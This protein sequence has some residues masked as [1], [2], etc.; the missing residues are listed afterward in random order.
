M[1]LQKDFGS[2]VREINGVTLL[3]N[4]QRFSDKGRPLHLLYCYW[5]PTRQH[6]KIALPVRLPPRTFCAPPGAQS[7]SATAPQ[8][9]VRDNN[10]RLGHGN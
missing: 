4:V 9:E 10:W 3:V 5:T 2:Q 6:W 8:R 7:K 1:V